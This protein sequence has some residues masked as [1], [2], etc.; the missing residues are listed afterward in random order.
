M[1]LAN[2]PPLGLKPGK[3]KPD[4]AYLARVRELPCVSC[5]KPG[6]SE[7][8]HCRDLPDY[9]KRGIYERLPGAAQKSSDRDAIPLC[10]DCHRMFHLRRSEFH[11]KR[12]KDYLFIPETRGAI[13]NVVSDWT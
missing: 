8:H 5:Y 4:P 3:V 11:A 7:A 6:P 10:P 12:G 2:R 9:E 13:D 1:N